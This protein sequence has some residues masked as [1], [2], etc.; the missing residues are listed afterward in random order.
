MLK[1][2]QLLMI[3]KQVLVHTRF[4]RYILESC[5][6]VS[7]RLLLFMLAAQLGSLLN[8]TDDDWNSFDAYGVKLVANDIVV[9]QARNKDA[10]F[11]LQF[12]PFITS[13]LTLPC[14]VDYV[15]VGLDENSFIYSIVIPKQYLK[16]ASVVFIGENND[17]STSPYPFVGH[18]RVNSSCQATYA[19]QFFVTQSHNEFFVI[20]ID[21]T[22]EV[23]YGFASTFAFSYYLQAHSI[24]YLQPWPISN[25]MPRAVD[26]GN[27]DVAVIA[28]FHSQT[29]NTCK[30][31]VYMLKLNLS[32]LSVLDEWDYVPSNSSWQANALCIDAAKFTTKHVMSVAIH[33][34]T[35][36]LLVGVP[37]MNIVFWFH[38][39]T[40]LT[41]AAYREN[42]NQRGYGQSLGWSGE[43]GGPF[44]VVL[45]NAYDFP[46]TWSSSII[47][48]FTVDEFT[49]S[50]PIMPLFPT[51]QYPP[52][53]ELESKLTTIATATIN[54]AFLDSS[55]QIY[56]IVAAP[57]GSY[58]DT[59][60]TLGL[61]PAFSIATLCPPGTY[62]DWIGIYICYLCPT[63]E[64]SDLEGSIECS[65]YNCS[66]NN[67]F[68]P[69]G[70]ITNDTYSD[71]N[72]V[73]SGQ[74]RYPDSPET[75]NFDDILIMH[76]FT[77][78]DSSRCLVVSPLFWMMIMMFIASLVIIVMGVLKF[79]KQYTNVRLTLKRIF[80]QADLIRE[81]EVW[82]GGLASFSLIVLL[83]FSYIFSS[84]FLNQYPIETALPSKL[85]C[86]TTIRNTRFD[87]NFQSL[88]TALSNHEQN[89]FTL[90]D[91]QQFILTID[92]INTK[93]KCD[94]VS[95]TQMTHANLKAIAF[96][97]TYNR[98]MLSVSIALD[99]HIRSMNYK[100]NRAKQIGGFRISLHGKE[101]GTSD[102]TGKYK[103]YIRE[104]DFMQSFLS[105]NHTL[106]S[107]PTVELSLTRIINKTQPLDDS[108]PYEFTA[109]WAL[110]SIASVS[111]LFLTFEEYLYYG[112]L[113]TS[114]SI[115]ISEVSYYVMNTQKPIT[116]RA[117]LIFHNLLFTTVCIELFGLAYLTI[118]LFFLP[119]FHH[120]RAFIE[121]RFNVIDS[122]EA[123]RPSEPVV[124]STKQQSPPSM[125]LTQHKEETMHRPT[126]R[127]K[128]APPTNRSKK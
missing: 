47:Y 42:G 16:D 87:T 94:E 88:S 59:S 43:Y 61:N 63:G 57:M 44:P 22:G 126:T 2:N 23:A 89:M 103:Y 40:N 8:F 36:Q 110:Q 81:G 50:D 32:S 73:V 119:I 18:L 85:A 38:M 75:T 100:F 41:I 56:V 68:C 86:D 96:N 118:K 84:D 125:L 74:P 27:D 14:Y 60:V 92:F 120:V 6:M 127:K 99:S 80:R 124:D 77:F 48:W 71:L 93:Q 13:N 83:L 46:H 37:S 111:K 4:S 98:S 90:L 67:A 19:L 33:P 102:T 24:T 5:K 49:S 55:G 15:A 21:P 12:G 109:I 58:P 25:F 1:Y 9:V 91:Q 28:G 26:L 122:K 10:Q 108:S 62:K 51:I 34:N 30:P 53:I 17:Y 76:M 128:I 20:G 113:K 7:V 66:E 45:G 69:L 65:S 106:A 123:L 95:V 54:V 39:S 105:N 121:K 79:F 101:H 3:S 107:D 31:L 72:T 116:K 52:W 97:C 114:F 35:S 82:V 104:L 115:S 29:Q 11:V 112:L 117:E 64:M 70:S 78:G